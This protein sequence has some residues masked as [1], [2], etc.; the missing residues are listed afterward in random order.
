MSNTPVT[1]LACELIK[2][3]SISPKDEGCQE[4]ITDFLKKLKFN[5][6]DMSHIDT[7]NLYATHGSG[8]PNFC[9]AGHTD[10]VPPGEITS[11]KTDPFKP[12]IIDG[13][14]YGRGAADMKGGDAA[15]LIAAQNFITKH[16][17]HKGTIS[18]MF[19]SDE[20]ADFINGTPQIIKKLQE[21]NENVDICIVGE[22]SSAKILCDTMKNGRRGS[23]TANIKVFG[24]QGHV[25]YPER[26]ENPIHKA[27]PAIT[28]LVNIKWD[29]GNDFFP[30]T[31]M[32]IP[33]IKAGTGAN[34]VIP[35]ELYIQ[36]NWRFCTET[37][38]DNIKEIVNNILTKHNLR[39]EISWS[40]SGDPFITKPGTL[41]NAT[42]QAIKEIQNIDCKLSTAGGTSDGRFIAK[43]N[44]CQV[45][46]LG[47][48]SSTIHK[49]N[50]CVNV[51][52]LEQL[53]KIYER[54]LEIIMI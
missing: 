27:A 48:I 33:N 4:L 16:P 3:P 1:D 15:M 40:F 37:T 26:G 29:N 41:V 14:L 30:P 9:F 45:I 46:E 6:E 47:P 52:D 12:T 7:T 36:I 31:S 10:V 54:I 17:N 2:R 42:K 13:I 24:I 32:Q 28:E 5:V 8:Y 43:M 50:E 19:T 21:R 18:F 25:A 38:A 23:I 53:A 35:G 39:Y 51:N 49:A 44:N 20:E 22:P 11:W 34:N